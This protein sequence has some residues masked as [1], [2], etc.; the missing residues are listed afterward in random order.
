MAA[1]A[2][3]VSACVR[4]SADVSFSNPY[5]SPHEFLAGIYRADH[6]TGAILPSHLA[7]VP[8]HLVAHD[9]IALGIRSVSL[10]KPK[11]IIVLSPDHFD[12]CTKTLC[13]TNGV[14]KTPLGDVPLA[15]FYI[16]PSMI[17]PSISP[18]LFQNEHG[19]HALLPFITHYMPDI[20]VMPIVVSQTL[21]RHEREQIFALLS[22]L[23]DDD[24]VLIVSTDFSH[25]LTLQEADDIDKQTRSAL[26]SLDT[27]VMLQF[28]QPDQSD[29][30][31]C[32]WLATSLADQNGWKP[33]ILSHTNSARLIGDESVSET[34]SHFT[35]MYR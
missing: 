2:M 35:V 4:Q 11:R 9:G 8:H 12:V 31:G 3:A 13:T 16:S 10:S 20:P 1:S 32:V 29:C 15:L 17:Q 18:S 21:W 22:S 30:P 28:R 5:S 27:D 24:T 7:I 14:F 6:A 33:I 26:L 34:T 25:Y 23:L 19:I